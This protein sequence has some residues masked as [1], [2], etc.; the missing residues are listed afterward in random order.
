MPILVP[1]LVQDVLLTWHLPGNATFDHVSRPGSMAW[2]ATSSMNLSARS[3]WQT[4]SGP[5]VSSGG[6]TSFECGWA[7]QSSSGSGKTTA[8][9]V[10]RFHSGFRA[11][12]VRILLRSYTALT[13]AGKKWRGGSSR[14]SRK[15][16]SAPRPCRAA[17]PVPARNSSRRLFTASLGAEAAP[18]LWDV[19]PPTGITASVRRVT[20]CGCH[21]KARVAADGDYVSLPGSRGQRLSYSFV[22]RETDR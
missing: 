16:I 4:T 14:R 17:G 2:E 8:S 20:L 10:L 5:K 13:T 21:R 3:A 7:L 11:G 15:I 1:P 18:A 22:F 6:G 9:L 19:L 12:P